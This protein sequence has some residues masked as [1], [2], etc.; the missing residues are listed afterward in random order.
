MDPLE[1]FAELAPKTRRARNWTGVP[2]TAFCR[3]LGVVLA[4][5]QLAF[6][7]VAYDGLEPKDLPTPELRAMAREIFGPLDVIPPEARRV[8]VL[9]AGARG[10]KSYVVAALR[11]LHLA[12]TVDLS[13]L[14]PGEEAFGVII[15]PN[16]QQRDQCYGY[17]LG[18]AQNC[19][20]VAALIVGEPG[21]ESFTLRRSDGRQVVI[22]GLPA[23]R[24]GG[25]ARGRSLVCAVLEECA[26]FLDADY[27]VNDADIFQAAMPRVLPG[28]Q[29]ILSSTPWAEAGLLYD[30]FIA[31]HPEPQR[32]AP[33]LTTHGHPHRAL[34]AHAPTLLFRDVPFT[35][36]IVQAETARD[37]VNAQREYGAQFMPLGAVM[38]FD[39]VS[40]A[41]SVDATLELGAELPRVDQQLV[42]VGADLGFRHDAFVGTAVDRQPHAYTLRAYVERLAAV[43]RIKPS[44]AYAELAQLAQQYGS[45]EV[46][47]DLHY[48]DSAEESLW[49]SSA[50][51]WIDLPG[52]QKGKAD[53]Y[54]V[55]KLL[56]DE[57]LLKLPN[58]ARLL[59]QLREVKKKPLPGGGLSIE[60]P[61]KPKGGHGD[62]V[63]ALVAAVWRL[64]KL[65]LPAAPEQL[66]ADV[67]ERDAVLWER[68]IN[69]RIAADERREYLERQGILPLEDDF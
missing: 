17:A 41:Q 58:D 8:I 33:H 35:R 57:G 34:A 62:I 5:G 30:E 55:V 21:V 23:K 49:D 25:A 13:G 48:A 9:V 15:A 67:V 66:P 18:A 29:T 6:A 52:G 61:R 44:Q 10:G 22:E 39:P 68:R 38:F 3:E 12:L 24:G 7:L 19:P 14:A 59:Q 60:S 42:C 1:A 54:M 37:P 31:N 64:S 43:E 27:V 47:G 26:F 50:V 51:V 4:L 45:T 56:M 40:I 11:C 2:F 63:S 32:A 36:E 69:E 65:Q 53:T 28:G 20:D 16:P 46:V